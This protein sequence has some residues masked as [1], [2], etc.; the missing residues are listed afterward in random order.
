VAIANP[1]THRKKP[2]FIIAG[3]AAVITSMLS[4]AV[5][6]E[7]GTAPKA[8][9][10]VID[11]A[12]WD[13][14]E[15]G[16]IAL[17]G[18]WKLIWGESRPEFSGKEFD[19]SEWQNF[20]V[21]DYWDKV[22][23]TSEGFGWLRL[24]IKNLKDGSFPLALFQKGAQTAQ[25]IFVNGV[26][27]MHAGNPG[28]PGEPP[29]PAIFP[30]VAPISAENETVIAWNIAN[31]HNRHGGPR[32]SPVL[33]PYHALAF[34]LWIS[35]MR[36]ALAVGF[37][38]MMSIYNFIL[39]L[40]MKEERASL[41]FALFC[42]MIAFRCMFMEAYIQRLLADVNVFDVYKRV[43][44]VVNLSAVAFFL[45]FLQRF[46]PED[47]S[48]RI[49]RIANWI[50][51]AAIMDAVLTPV[52]INN[53]LM[54]VVYF[55]VAIYMGWLIVSVLNAVKRKRD[56]AKIVLASIVILLAAI[57]NDIVTITFPYFGTFNL[58]EIG[59]IG[60]IICYS[61]ILSLR[62]ARAL[63][64]SQRL[65]Q[66]WREE[67]DKQTETITQ[68][69][70]EL[71]QLVREKT[72]L[73]INFS[74]ETKTPLTLMSNALEK[75]IEDR[76]ADERLDLLKRNLKKMERD[77]T[78]SLDLEKLMRGQDFYRHGR[79]VS[80][81][82]V[83]KE[84]MLLY[85][86]TAKQHGLEL[87]LAAAPD[88]FVSIDPFALDRTINNL[89][90]NAIRYT[91]WGGKITVSLEAVGDTISLTVADTGIGI[92]AEMQKTI[93]EPYYQI[94]H[95]KGN[96]Q[97]MGMG[98]SI[99]KQI[100]DSLGS[101][102]RLQ[103]EEGKGSSFTLIFPAS[104]PP[105]ANETRPQTA[106]LSAPDLSKTSVSLPDEAFSADK[107]T[108]LVV[109]DNRDMLAFLAEELQEG[110]NVFQASSGDEALKM[111]AVMPPPQ[112]IL[113]DVMMDGMDGFAFL[114]ALGRSEEYRSIP[115]VFLSARSRQED[116]LAGLSRGAVDFIP[117]PFSIVELKIK[118][119]A[120]IHSHQTQREAVVMEMREKLDSLGR[121]GE[122]GRMQQSRQEESFRRFRITKRERDVI[123]LLLQGMEY[124]EIADRLTITFGTLKM[125]VI[126]IY[127]KCGVHNK[128]ELAH[129]F[130]PA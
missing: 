83:L 115:L 118:I 29:A 44:M 71:E 103:S 34:E 114:D 58:V 56:Y 38:L 80:L 55:V 27:I 81:S 86:E 40:I 60:V 18:E 28:Q 36:G 8:V 125:Y 16:P 112:L 121:A 90:D 104:P 33:G 46:Y 66:N 35:D 98:L 110:Y 7:S 42:L 14:V 65:S 6:E 85:K 23:G 48:P 101:E 19:D 57:I 10:G 82:E 1:L 100:M 26:E 17:S 78:N 102:I 126:N 91:E 22:E 41:Y 30:Q 108:L 124:K 87:V 96:A 75:Y 43:D 32:F 116:R 109:E 53:Y 15:S 64:T 59:T 31:F 94:S 3:L 69:N 127:K 93:F 88:C 117:K 70:S 72:D 67:V 5:P 20:T 39:W 51:L 128:I 21:P 99:V 76:G 120:L 111:L 73:F 84:K 123:L 89:L 129:I 130:N 9:N 13:F 95:K 2:I 68:Q 24:R 37:I 61:S 12:G 113:S 97:G 62:F 74:H 106:A 47:V 11:L 105:A 63:R 4:C 119:R 92:P 107:E 122:R 45:L 52:W 50:N 79:A 49:M 25:R 77:V 54:N